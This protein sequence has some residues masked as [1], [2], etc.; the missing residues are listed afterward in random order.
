MSDSQCCNTVGEYC[1]YTGDA[2][3]C[4]GAA[5]VDATGQANGSDE[6]DGG[7][8]ENIV[9]KGGAAMFGG[10]CSAEGSPCLAER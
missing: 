1:L 3:Y 8:V 6:R 4:G 10:G 2:L 9:K 5:A 7:F